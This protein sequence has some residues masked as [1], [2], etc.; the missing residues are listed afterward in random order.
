MFTNVSGDII[1]TNLS[2]RN[3]CLQFMMRFGLIKQETDSEWHWIDQGGDFMG[4]AMADEELT[5]EI[6]DTLYYRFEAVQDVLLQNASSGEFMAKS[7]EDISL[8]VWYDGKQ[9]ATSDKAELIQLYFSYN[10][11]C[12]FDTVTITECL[13]TEDEEE[14][15]NKYPDI[16][17]SSMLWEIL[18]DAASQALL[19]LKNTGS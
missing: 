3:N 2:S 12:L 16:S 13:Q 19:N 11:N 9:F 6:P 1:F 4:I 7:D 18:D 15:S 8:F 14:F 17:H 10:P 5:L